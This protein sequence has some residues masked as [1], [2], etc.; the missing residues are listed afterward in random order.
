[1][2]YFTK[3]TKINCKFKDKNHKSYIDM[4]WSICLI[5]YSMSDWEDATFAQMRPD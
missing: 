4:K 2:V 3:A 1:M 5:P